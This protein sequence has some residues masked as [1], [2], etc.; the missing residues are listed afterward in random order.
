MAQKDNSP[1][2]LDI[3]LI[4]VFTF[5][6]FVWSC[7]QCR[8]KP[9]TTTN[10]EQRDSA[11]TTRPNPTQ[12]VATTPT[13]VTPTPTPAPVQPVTPPTRSA[14]ANNAV[15]YVV[16]DSLKMRSEPRKDAPIIAVLRV[17]EQISF[18][19]ERSKTNQ[20]IKLN[21]IEYN[22]PWL[23]VRTINNKAGWVYGAGVRSYPRD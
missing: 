10:T 7:R 5:I 17:N 6:L 19:G 14:V 18:T 15:L 4:A 11:T 9:A 2:R 3:I 13:N 20:K 23:M 8:R 16:I 12:P 21:N 1:L 22:E